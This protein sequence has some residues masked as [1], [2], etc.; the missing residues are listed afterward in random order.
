MINLMSM[1]LLICLKMTNNL[2]MQKS[3]HWEL[4]AHGKKETPLEKYYRLKLETEEL[5][6][7]INSLQENKND[8]D[9]QS[10][11]N[12]GSQ[13]QSVLLKLSTLNVEKSLE[14]QLGM[15][16][17]SDIDNLQ[18]YI[19]TVTELLKKQ[20]DINDKSQVTKENV[21][22][23]L[24]F[25]AL[26]RPNRAQLD[27]VSQ[28]SRLEERLRKLEGTVGSGALS[29]K[30]LGICENGGL[31]EAVRL[32]LGQLS[33]LDSSQL[34]AVDTRVSNLLPKLE[35]TAAKLDGQDNEKDKKINE[36][37]ETVLK[38]K[39]EAHLLPDV[40]QRMVALESLH[41]KVGKLVVTISNLNAQHAENYQNIEK[42]GAFLKTIESHINENMI[43]INSNLQSLNTRV[44][45][46]AEKLKKSG[47][48]S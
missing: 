12:I 43:K 2:I 8:L 17:A 30:R 24:N 38:A 25:Q 35:Q 34:D 1:K 37:Y 21:S 4:A 23:A 26:I 46:V 13:V 28:I 31:I 44:E 14:Q 36:L 18:K 7:E 33:V 47:D 48:K 11:A 27:Q 42:N 19:E 15:L 20:P 9:E 6:Q 29:L 5:V 3:E 10:C 40:L 39:K 22:Q 32:L 45:V 41:Q 16:G